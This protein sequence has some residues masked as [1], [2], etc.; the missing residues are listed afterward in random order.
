MHC[1]IPSRRSDR[2]RSKE[3]VGKNNGCKIPQSEK[4]N[5]TKNS[6]NSKNSNQDYSKGTNT[7]THKLSKVKDKGRLLKSAK[8]K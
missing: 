5:V 7:E 2:E 8:G 4:E 3:L 1:G 6:R